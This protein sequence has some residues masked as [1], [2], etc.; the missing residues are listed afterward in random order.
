MSTEK[1]KPEET[2]TFEQ[3]V[4]RLEQ[5]VTEMESG[6]QELDAMVQSFDEGQKLVSFCGDK[7]AGIERK[8]EQLTRKNDGTTGTAPFPEG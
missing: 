8:V 2:M 1:S 4:R 5:L 7:L 3:A 6:T